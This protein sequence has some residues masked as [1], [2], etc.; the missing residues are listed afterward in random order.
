MQIYIGSLRGKTAIVHNR[1]IGKELK[2]GSIVAVNH[3][4][5]VGTIPQIAQVVSVP[6]EPS[7][8]TQ[9]EIQWFE[10]ERA[11]HKPRRRRCYTQST[12]YANSYVTLRN[13]LLYDIEL[14][15]TGVKNL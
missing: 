2:S 10:E 6:S 8:D 7:L 12:K 3:P 11:P 13:I 5:W 4:S 9:V 15:R 1:E 14:N